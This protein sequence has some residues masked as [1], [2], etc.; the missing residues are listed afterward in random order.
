MRQLLTNPETL[1]NNPRTTYYVRKLHTNIETTYYPGNLLCGFGVYFESPRAN[2]WPNEQ[3]IVEVAQS[4][5]HAWF[6]KHL[7]IR[8]LGF[9]SSSV[10]SSMLQTTRQ[11]L[12]GIR[13][14]SQLLTNPG[15]YSI[16]QELLTI[17][18]IYPL[19]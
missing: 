1:L 16:Q 5:V 12:I 4:E 3:F 8:D 6:L 9:N 18:R 2:R 14:V 10:D 13:L 15:I 19:I 11:I 17:P 7:N